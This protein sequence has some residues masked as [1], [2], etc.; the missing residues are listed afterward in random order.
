VIDLHAAA[1]V[2]LAHE[3]V[4][5]DQVVDGSP[6]T[7]YAALGEFAGQEYGVW[8]MSVGAMSDVEEDELFIVISGAGELT[9]EGGE[10]RTLEAGVVGRLE[11]GQRT[12]WS[13]TS[14]LRKVYVAGEA[15]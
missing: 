14:T 5:A 12:V 11:A 7:G 3:P 4:A 15:S 8:E 6:T 10:T 2:E 9:L 13:V 1:A